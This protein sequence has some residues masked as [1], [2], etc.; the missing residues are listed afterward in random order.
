MATLDE[1]E[2]TIHRLMRYAE[3]IDPSYR[4]MLPSRRTI[5]AHCPDI[6]RTWHAHWRD[7][8]ISDLEA[9]ALGRR[10]DIRLTVRSDDLL[11]MARGELDPR[12]AY[13]DDRIKVE[14][15]MTDLLRLRAIL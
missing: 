4:A 12:R 11:A 8:A 15:S 5:E 2:A 1:V 7:G 13:G 9:G 3:R 6:D 14:A 10:A